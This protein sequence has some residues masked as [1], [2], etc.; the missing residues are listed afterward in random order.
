M[1]HELE[2]LR[3]ELTEKS[4]EVMKLRKQVSFQ[5][6]RGATYLQHNKYNLLCLKYIDNNNYIWMID[7]WH[8]YSCPTLHYIDVGQ[9]MIIGEAEICGF[10]V[11]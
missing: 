8:F 1:E 9:V 3:R 7:T 4:I 2:G 6:C 10:C 5:V 11:A